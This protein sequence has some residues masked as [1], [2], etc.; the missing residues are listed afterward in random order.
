M[1][2]PTNIVTTARGPCRDGVLRMPITQAPDIVEARHAARQLAAEAGLAGTDLTLLA[3]AVSEV[4]RN[5]VQFTTGGEIVITV[6]RVGSRR[7]V[8]VTACD[9]GPGIP[10]VDRALADGYSTS[11][12]LGLGL[13][14]ARRLMD[15][16]ALA[17]DARGGTTVTMI[18]WCHQP[19]R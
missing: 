1:P 2:R 19:S 18:K 16:F 7:G 4:A 12:G 13:P 14:G 11:H 5:I 6:V 17:S 8:K 3:T 10:D 9:R 15:E